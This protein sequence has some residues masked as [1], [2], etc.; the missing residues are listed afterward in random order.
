M[1]TDK[2]ENARN[3]NG[4]DFSQANPLLYMALNDTEQF[5][6]VVL[7]LPKESGG[8]PHSFPGSEK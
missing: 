2:S 5:E 8:R 4:S 3:A 1:K 6:R 7:D